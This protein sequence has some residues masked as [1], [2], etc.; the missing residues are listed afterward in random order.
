MPDK[1]IQR[2]YSAYRTLTQCG[3]VRFSLAEFRAWIAAQ[4][5]SPYCPYC[6]TVILDTWSVDHKMPV[7]KGGLNSFDNLQLVCLR[8]NHRKGDFCDAEYRD[9]LEMLDELELRHRN[10]KLKSR[11]LVALQ[12]SLSFRKGK[13]R[14]RT[15]L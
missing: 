6:R 7:S 9:L 3:Q 8:C 15:T 4:L 5:K 10:F 12:V 11:V 14:R 13:Q 1:F 2:S